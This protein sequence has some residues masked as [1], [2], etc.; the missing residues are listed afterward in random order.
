MNGIMIMKSR[1]KLE[2]YKTW[3]GN[4]DN[5]GWAANVNYIFL[6]YKLYLIL[7]IFTT[8]RR[9]FSGQFVMKYED[10]RDRNLNRYLECNA[11]TIKQGAQ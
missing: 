2:I 10:F 7:A 11:N 1:W 9:E 6:G 3:S 5:L 4:T 8:I